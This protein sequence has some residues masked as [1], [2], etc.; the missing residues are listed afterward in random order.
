MPGYKI[1]DRHLADAT[2]LCAAAAFEAVQP[3][4]DPRG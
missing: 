4:L 3:F 1:I 2:V